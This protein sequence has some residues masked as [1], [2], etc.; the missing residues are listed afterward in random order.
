[1]DKEEESYY[2]ID[3][4]NSRKNQ[5]Q[6][7]KPGFFGGVRRRETV[8]G[9]TKEGKNKPAKLFQV[10]RRKIKLIRCEFPR[11]GNVGRRKGKTRMGLRRRAE[12]TL[13][14]RRLERRPL[15]GGGK[16]A[17]FGTAEQR[18]LEGRSDIRGYMA[19]WLGGGKVWTGSTL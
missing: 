18:A 13:F 9:A 7:L 6:E 5:Q 19:H 2:R 8:R 17:D 3:S 11:S 4:Q 14:R 1:M 12:S 15:S 10:R 16:S